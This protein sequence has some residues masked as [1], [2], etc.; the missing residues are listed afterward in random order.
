MIQHAPA[1]L[2]L[3]ALCALSACVL[4]ACGGGGG[5]DPSGGLGSVTGVLS[6]LEQG[7]S[8]VLQNNGSD[9][10][11]LSANG[12][13]AFAHAVAPGAPYAVA[14]KTQPAGQQCTVGQGTGTLA[15][16]PTNVRVDCVSAGAGFTLGG[17]VSGVPGGQAVVLTTA[18]G[19][20]L[21]VAADGAF[22][23]ARPLAN[24]ASY[25]VTVKM[26]PVGV[27]AS[28]IVISSASRTLTRGWS[29]FH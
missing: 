23:F 13:F 11:A 16:M 2:S 17:T 28:A 5:D 12:A 15:A 22:T 6:G 27:S 1:R 19:E 29:W 3:T 21:A 24:G 9:D 14:V 8:L 10:L 25:S 26:A 7:K 4:A 18:G 20:D